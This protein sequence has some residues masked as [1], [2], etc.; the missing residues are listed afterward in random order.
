[1]V[2]RK[3]RGKLQEELKQWINDDLSDLC[4]ILGLTRSGNKHHLVQR[5]LKS[6]YDRQYVE[7]RRNFLSFGLSL[8]G[9]YTSSQL[10]DITREHDL[11]KQ[12]TKRDKM[13]EI[14][15]SEAITPREL[16]G[17]LES[18]ELEEIYEELYEKEPALG[19][20]GIIREIIKYHNL[21]WLDEIMDAGFIIMPI[22]DDEFT[23]KTYRSIKYVCKKFDI[24]AVRI[25]EMN[26]SGVVTEEILE[27]I[28]ASDYLIVDITNE[29]PNVY[30]ELGF[31]HG[32][33]KDFEKIVLMARK[34]TKRHFDIQSMRAIIYKDHK[35]LRRA[36]HKRLKAITGKV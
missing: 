32:L 30:Y 14:L 12:S 22:S 6:E 28:K 15:K 34:G 16:L 8:V 7:E 4:Y 35:G 11:P 9:S 23:R 17:Q 31:A 10:T 13:I 18:D 20:E 19:R 2:D 27:K 25:D 29:R 1:M 26:T 33:G 3:D 36:L 24:N 5:I 21:N